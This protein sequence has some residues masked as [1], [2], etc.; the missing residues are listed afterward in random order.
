MVDSSP[1]TDGLGMGVGSRLR[2]ENVRGLVGKEPHSQA[3]PSM[4]SCLDATPG[5]GQSPCAYEG[6]QTEGVKSCRQA[7]LVSSGWC[8]VAVLVFSGTSYHVK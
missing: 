5:T 2:H 7:E 4:R 3:V 1:G 6:S 8:W